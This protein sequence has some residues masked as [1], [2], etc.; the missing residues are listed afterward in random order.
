MRPYRGI[1]L[2]TV[3]VV[4]WCSRRVSLTPGALGELAPGG[5]PAPRYTLDFIIEIHEMK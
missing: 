3:K 4:D 5:W 2:G 1:Y